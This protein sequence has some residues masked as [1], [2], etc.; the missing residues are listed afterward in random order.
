MTYT[1]NPEPDWSARPWGRPRLYTAMVAPIENPTLLAICEFR[2]HGM[3]VRGVR[4]YRSED[5]VIRVGMP[6]KRFGDTIRPAIYFI[7]PADRDLF[8][9]D[10]VWL[11]CNTIG[12]KRRTP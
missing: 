11:Y 6:Q 10:V 12:K 1:I 8:E 7:D 2:C 9:S 5:G 4:V 3:H